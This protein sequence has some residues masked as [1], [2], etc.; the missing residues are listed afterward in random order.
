MLN[1]LIKML[2]PKMPDTIR[3]RVKETFGSHQEEFRA[4]LYHIRGQFERNQ[5]AYYAIPKWN[6]IARMKQ[7]IKIQAYRETYQECF[8]AFFNGAIYRNLQ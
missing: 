1:W 6:V 7:E 5:E 3:P 4:L 8:Q 2:S